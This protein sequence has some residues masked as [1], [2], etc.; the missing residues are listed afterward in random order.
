MVGEPDSSEPSPGDLRAFAETVVGEV[1]TPNDEAY[2][3]ARRVWNGMINR[4]PAAVVRCAGV[5]DVVDAVGFAREHDLDLAVRGG[6][7]NVAGNATCDGG[8]VV[9]LS[10]MNAVRVSPSTKTARVEGGARW[11]DVDRE[12]QR[13]GLATPGGVVSDTGVAGLTLG[14]GM[15]HLRRAYGLSCDTLVSADVVTAEGDLVTASADENPDL[16]WALRGGGGNFGVVTSFEFVLYEVGPEVAVLFVWHRADRAVEH[17]SAFRE[18]AVDAPDEASVLAFY[19]WVPAEEPFPAESWGEPAVV[20]LGAYAGDTDAGMET[21]DPLRTLEEPIGDFGGPLPYVELQSMLDADYP[22]GMLYYWKS[23]Y[24]DSLDDE[25]V[26]RIVAVS[27]ECPVPASTVDLW[28]LGGAIEAVEES[29]T[30]YANR[31][32]PYLLNFEANWTDPRETGAAVAWVRDSVASFRELAG[33]R[34]EYVNFAGFGED[35]T[36]VAYGEQYDRLVEVKTA[37]DPANLF[38]LN[39]NVPPET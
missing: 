21:F 6:G 24:L 9:D 13:F 8:L 29:A 28:H 36:R 5:G 19:A 26:A 38:R 20:F 2:R 33:T 37:Y 3:E 34:G 16:F 32:A 25:V 22:H 27:E 31:D 35:P 17:L 23:L 11:A 30:V 4:F 10:A 14:G 39:R 1:L 12:T 7:H 18:W 15:G